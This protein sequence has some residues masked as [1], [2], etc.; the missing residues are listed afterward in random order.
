MLTL[1]DWTT[2]V[3]S[4]LT[5]Q[6]NAIDAQGRRNTCKPDRNGHMIYFTPRT[7][8]MHP[9]YGLILT[10]R[11]GR[12]VVPAGVPWCADN[13]AFTGQFDW[14]RFERFLRAMQP[15][16]ATCRFVA[17]PDVV[18]NAVATLD[19]YRYYAWRIKALGYP[20]A[21]VAQDGLESLRW[22]PEYDA[23]FIGGSTGWKLSG[24][25]LH[26]IARAQ[27]AGA[28]VHVGRV[29]GAKR[30]RHFRIAGVDSC[31]GTHLTYNPGWFMHN[32]LLAGLLQP[33]LIEDNP[34]C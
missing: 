34:A 33:A 4:G 11:S 13:G 1:S 22:P 16:A 10:P 30:I 3:T 17:A 24:A 8:F 6:R 12:T 21:L 29:N 7:S 26:C 14:A 18:G 2:V 19:R 32:R 31:D 23:L 5:H 15:E 28:W 9:T 20:V 25:A 27:A